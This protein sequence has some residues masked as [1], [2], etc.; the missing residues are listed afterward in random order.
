M[1][2]T[3]INKNMEQLVLTECKKA[4]TYPHN[5]QNPDLTTAEH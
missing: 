3:N 4:K 1:S 5:I 2:L